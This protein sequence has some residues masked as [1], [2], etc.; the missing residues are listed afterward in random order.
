MSMRSLLRG[1]SQ[2]CIT[3]GLFL[4]VLALYGVLMVKIGVTD[5]EVGSYTVTSILLPN[6]INGGVAIVL[7]LILLGAWQTWRTRHVLA[8]LRNRQE[9]IPDPRMRGLLAMV[10]A[11][12]E[13]LGMAESKLAELDLI[14][15]QCPEIAIL[16]KDY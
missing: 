14:F 12:G 13:E 9:S 8:L 3:I 4:I 2:T 16:L 11:K 6:L 5:N 1:M 7:G 10:H 15:E